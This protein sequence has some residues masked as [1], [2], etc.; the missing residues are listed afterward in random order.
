[1][2]R[3]MMSIRSGAIWLAIAT[4]LFACATPGMS[5]GDPEA[6]SGCHSVY[7]SIYIPPTR[8]GGSGH[9]QQVRVGED[10]EINSNYSDVVAQLASAGTAYDERRALQ[11][12]HRR[13]AIINYFN[14]S[15]HEYR[16]DRVFE[17]WI[18]QEAGNFEDNRAAAGNNLRNYVRLMSLIATLDHGQ[19]YR[20]DESARL[21]AYPIDTDIS[22]SHPEFWPFSEGVSRQGHSVNVPL[23]QVALDGAARLRQSLAE[24]YLDGFSNIEEACAANEIRQQPPSGPFTADGDGAISIAL[25]PYQSEA[26]EREFVDWHQRSDLQD[27]ELASTPAR[28]DLVILIVRDFSSERSRNPAGAAWR[29]SHL[30]SDLFVSSA[31]SPEL[32]RSRELYGWQLSLGW[33]GFFGEHQMRGLWQ[34]F[35]ADA[36]LDCRLDSSRSSEYCMA[37]GDSHRI[38]RT[39]RIILPLA[40]DEMI[41]VDTGRLR[42][43]ATLSNAL[44]RRPSVMQIQPVEGDRPARM[45]CMVSGNLDGASLAEE[46]SACVEF[47][48]SPQSDPI[49]DCVWPWLFSDFR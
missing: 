49:E 40:S 25:A 45:A 43:P 16:M 20:W 22:V 12:D 48:V 46:F 30:D 15:N 35:A 44:Y 32:D 29:P 6:T 21:Q 18:Q 7:T 31:E 3:L 38:V 14:Y 28:A 34:A 33:M 26:Y 27:V 39:E 42:P 36:A 8:L 13:A 4:G 1:M 11:L 47:A 5:T 19:G 2:I 10:C 23:R 24:N 9:V 37:N 41:I 17:E